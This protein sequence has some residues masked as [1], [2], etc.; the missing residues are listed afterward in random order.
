MRITDFF[1]TDPRNRINIV[2]PYIIAEAG[3]NHE[4]SMDIARRLIDEAKEG[5]ADG[6]K[7]Q[8]YRAATLAVKDSPAFW[9]TT[10][11]TATNQYE[12]YKKHENFWKDEFGILKEYCDNVGIDFMSS[13]FDTESATFLDPMM[14]A[15]KISSSDLTNKPFVEFLCNFGKPIILS[16][17]ASHLHEIQETVSWIEGKGNK[18][19]LLHCVLNYPTLDENAN[20]G[21]IRGL[22][23]QFPQHYIGY[24]DHTFPKD[25]KSLEIATMLG[26]TII[27]KHFT[28]DKSLPGNDHY[29]AMDLHD[30]KVFRNNLKRILNM[31]GD[32]SVRALNGEDRA[33]ANARRSLVAQG[34]ISKGDIITAEMLTWKRPAFG[35]SPKYIDL[36]IGKTAMQEIDD[37][38]V[39]QWN[40]FS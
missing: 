26:A 3:V 11:E 10:Q 39:L 35:I 17:G 4:G 15:F 9:D 22:I 12:L 21:M 24:S 33:R 37:D 19:A 34:R 14:D 13:A 23:R 40:M 31:I 20:L 36:L 27:E 7:F 30:L 38:S 1:A 5:G 28:H 16:T 6:I 29:H 32:G 2:E 18:L 25:M 8:T